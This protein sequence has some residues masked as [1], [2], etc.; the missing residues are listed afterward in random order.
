MLTIPLDTLGFIIEK[1]REF[2]AEVP[3]QDPD[4][5][6]NAADDG[7]AEILFDTADNPAAEELR[8]VIDDLNVDQQA[9]LLALTWVGRGDFSAGEWRDALAAAR[10]AMTTRESNYLMGTPLLG[11]YLEE[12]LAALGLSPES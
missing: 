4:E 12:G 2:D 10:D 11:D 6:S 5:G 1:A 9:E 8:H 3:P 7:E